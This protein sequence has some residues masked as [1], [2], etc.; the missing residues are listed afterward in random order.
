[1]LPYLRHGGA[2]V[3]PRLRPG[4]NSGTTV[5]PLRSDCGAMRSAL[6]VARTNPGATLEDPWRCRG[7]A[8]EMQ[9]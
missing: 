8:L 7:G 6:E 1:M 4:G 3:A 5:A 2:M 9:C